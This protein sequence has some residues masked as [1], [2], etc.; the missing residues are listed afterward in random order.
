MLK[1]FCA[2]AVLT[3]FAFLASP[4]AVLADHDFKVT[5]KGYHQID[6]VYLS[7]VDEDTW[8]PDQLD[9]DEVIASGEHQTWSIS[10]G[11]MQ[12]VKIVYHNGHKDIERNFNTCKYDLELS[13]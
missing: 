1:K 9:S 13:Y 5:N 8:G 10:D 2:L 11:C 12:D 6:H 3:G 4:T 7:N